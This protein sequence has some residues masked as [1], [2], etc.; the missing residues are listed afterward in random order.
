MTTYVYQRVLLMIPTVLIAS[1]LVF[2]LVRVLP[3]DLAAAALG[4]SASQEQVEA[5]RERLGLN[6]SL[7]VQFFDWISGVL[8]F[9]FGE[10]SV[11]GLSIGATLQNTLPVTI[12]LAVFSMV[13]GLV[14]GVPLGMLGAIYRGTFVDVLSQGVAILGLSVPLFVVGLLAILLPVIW[15]EWSPPVTYHPIWEDPIAN[16]GQFVLPSTILSLRLAGVNARMT[17]SAMLEVM[18]SDYIRTAHAKGLSPV[19][20]WSRHAL[21]NALVP[22]VTISGI[23]LVTL[24]GGVVIIEQIF[25]LPGLGRF[26]LDSVGPRDYVAVQ[27]IVLVMAV[28]A[29]LINI[30][31]DMSYLV[32]DPRLRVSR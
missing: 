31:V 7:P 8:V 14:I 21:R 24:L 25:G 28:A 4:E 1:V 26:L 19:R 12:E 18:G 6:D 3:G 23:Q 15:W 13:A 32:L 16:L 30:A 17:R 27:S 22:I 20:V 11:T 2:L 9:D 5:Y 29:A 10:S